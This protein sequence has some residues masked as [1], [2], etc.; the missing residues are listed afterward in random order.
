VVGKDH[1]PL[2]SGSYRNLISDDG[3]GKWHRDPKLW[4]GGTPQLCRSGWH[5]FPL[6]RVKAWTRDDFDNKPRNIW[7][8]EVFGKANWDYEKMC[9]EYIR[10]V[11]PLTAAET[12]LLEQ[13]NFP[14]PQEGWMD[15]KKDYI[16]AAALLG[17]EGLV[18]CYFKP[19]GVNR[20]R[21]V[22]QLL[23]ARPAKVTLPPVEKGKV[24]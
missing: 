21:H 7:L 2:G 6:S 1:P 19:V 22:P 16:S 18:L 17:V 24:A 3:L 14:D 12:I 4:R 13:R 20:D 15:V 9:A 23:R 11:S 10:F 5:V 8:V